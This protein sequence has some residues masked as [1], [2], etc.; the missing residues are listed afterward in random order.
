MS[1]PRYAVALSAMR[2]MPH[3]H[4][5]AG[6]MEQYLSAMI[7]NGG[8]FDDVNECAMTRAKE[9]APESDGWFGHAVC[10]VPEDGGLDQKPYGTEP[11]RV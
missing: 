4:P 2:R 3:G 10:V 7:V 11:V 8:T 6:D 9:R 1:Q 5:H